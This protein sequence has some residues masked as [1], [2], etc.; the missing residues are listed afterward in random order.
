MSDCQ[1]QYDLNSTSPTHIAPPS[2]AYTF[3]LLRVTLSSLIFTASCF[4][5]NAAHAQSVNGTVFR[6]Y[7]ANGIHDAREPGIAGINVDITDA[8]G[9]LVGNTVSTADGSYTAA[10]SVG[11]GTD[12]RVEFNSVPSFLQ[13]APAGNDSGTTVIFGQ[14]GDTGIDVG[15]HNPAQ[16]C[17]NAAALGD[18]EMVTSC[19]ITGV[20][21]GST[22]EAIISFDY[23]SGD[24]GPASNVD[25]PAKSVTATAQQVGPTWGLAYQSSSN[26]LF[27]AAFMKRHVAFASDGGTS[28]IFILNPDGSAVSEFLDLDTLL[29]PGVAGADPHPSGTDLDRD[30]NNNGANGPVDEAW[31]AVG[32][33]AFGDIDISDDEL[34][35]Y[36]VNLFD[37]SLYSISLGSDPA[38]PIAPTLA[39]NIAIDAIPNPCSNPD[40]ARPF[41]VGVKDNVVYV[42][43]VCSAESTQN[44]ND[45]SAYVYRFTTSGGFEATPI[46]NEPITHARGCAVRAATCTA[47][48]WGPWQPTFTVTA[49]SFTR[50]FVQPQPMLTDIEFDNN[51]L[52]L[53]FRDRFGDQTGFDQF[54]TNP[55]DNTLYRGDSAGS[56]VRACDVAGTLV[57]ESN[58]SCG[59]L[60]GAGAGNG[61]GPGGGQFYVIDFPDHDHV[62]LAG[63]AKAQGF[64]DL[65]FSMYDPIFNSAEFFDGGNG[66]NS[67]SNGAG[68]RRYRIYSTNDT[69]PSTFAKGGGLGDTELLCNAAPVEVGNRVWDDLNNNGVQ[70]AG[71]PG[72][73]G[74]TLNLSCT[75][76]TNA[77]T[78]SDALGQYLFNDANVSAGIPLN[79]ACDISISATDPGLGGRTLVIADTGSNPAVDSDGIDNAGTIIGDFIINAAGHNDH[80]IDFGFTSV[81]TITGDIGDKVWCDGL[82]TTGNNLFDTGEG[83]NN[84]TVDLFD[85]AN[86]DGTADS[87]TPLDTI[88]TST[89]GDYLFSS[90]TVGTAGAPVCYVTR[91]AANDPDLNGCD[92]LQTPPTFA[93]QLTDV[94]PQDLD[95]D[96]YFAAPIGSIGD[97]VWC[98]GVQGSGNNVFDTGEGLNGITVSLFSDNNCDGTADTA[99]ALAVTNTLNDGQYLFDTLAIG[100]S[101]SPVCY[102]TRVDTSDPDL[103]ACNIIQS[104]TE[105]A[106]QLTDTSPDDLTH[107]YYFVSPEG[108]IGDQVW[109]ESATNANTT[110]DPADGDTALVNI[111]VSL[112]AGTNCATTPT[113]AGALGQMVT[114]VNGQYQFTGLLVGAPGSNDVCYFVE[115][116]ASDADL[117][118]CNNPITPT[119]TISTLNT[120]TPVDNDNDF[121]FNIPVRLGDFVWY[122]HNLD[123][124]QDPS[125][126]PVPNLAVELYNNASCTATPFATTQTDANGFYLFDNLDPGSYCVQFIAPLNWSFTDQNQGN[127]D[128]LDSDVDPSN[129][130]ISNIT[131]TT[132]D[133]SFDAGLFAPIGAISGVLYC[134][135]NPLN[136][137]Q[138]AGE[139]LP[140]VSYSLE[141][142]LNCDGIADEFIEQQD[143]AADGSYSFTN[144]VVALSPA[145]PNP[146]VCYILSPDLDDPD[147]NGCII[148]VTGT[149]VMVPLSTDTPNSTGNMTT[150]IFF[151]NAVP[152]LNHIGLMIMALVFLLAGIHF[153]RRLFN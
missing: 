130:Q 133:L 32:K 129:G 11:A 86:C 49:T 75:D 108:L 122:D 50:E 57:L 43:G 19:Y 78:V 138:D 123:G 120:N 140:N 83:L 21:A 95:H 48:D 93:A 5:A 22:E 36:A 128:E 96:Y 146:Q 103:G 125:E 150:V 106:A 134:D 29:G 91:V 52:I 109:C 18:L 31:D 110:Y 147:L 115:V 100:S 51:D 42:G 28:K 104:N 14:S 136:G 99:P 85:D 101:G 153:R 139:E 59:S 1:P 80:R 55:A 58:G 135:S 118:N 151:I 87:G 145:P 54:G 70:D 46:L 73:P 63:L 116:D 114:D 69:D 124:I 132:D 27:A 25:L 56:V 72:L 97:Q 67:D 7:N 8:N 66:W 40:D 127:S 3:K 26:Q 47:A 16:Y 10:L 102:V 4:A 144:L 9:M 149:N 64:P 68:T 105:F 45:L 77:S 13:A 84:I 12:V 60:T 79:T 30:N 119:Q 17:Q 20:Q 15:F 61:R 143:T 137:S 41:A 6:D 82:L 117:G 131:L 44:R 71:E 35:L 39:S 121:G 2:H 141:R 33:R 76:G 152:A 37:R 89:D 38:N 24:T 92:L 107:D 126:A 113:P 62:A 148:P 98:D 65:T 112:S 142:D 34:T 23:L 88:T 90:L 111:S 53:G 94:D 74:V 81:R